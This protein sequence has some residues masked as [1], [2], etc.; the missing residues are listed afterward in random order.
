MAMPAHKKSPDVVLHRPI[1]TWLSVEDH[2]RL[3][4]IVERSGISVAAYIRAIVVDAIAEDAAR[5]AG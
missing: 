4:A 5:P 3:L 1:A 2:Q